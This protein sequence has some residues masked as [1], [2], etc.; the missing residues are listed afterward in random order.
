MAGQFNTINGNVNVYKAKGIS[1]PGWG[2]AMVQEK[3]MNTE[4]N[5]RC[6]GWYEH[7]YLFGGP[8]IHCQ[9]K[10]RASS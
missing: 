7:V 8:Q 1:K 9:S 10:F 5:V 2:L 4:Q 6:T 3:V